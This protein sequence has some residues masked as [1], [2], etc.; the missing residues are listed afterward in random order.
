MKVRVP[1][2]P[3]ALMLAVY[4]EIM[5]RVNAELDKWKAAASAIENDELREQALSSIEKKAFHC[6]GGS[7]YALLAGEAM[8]EAVEF[9]VA[10]QTISDYL[11]NLCDRSNSQDPEDFEMLHNSMK[12]ALLPDTPL[13]DWYSLR[14]DREYHYLAALVA[15]CRRVIAK[16]GFNSSSST[17]KEMLKLN[18]MY[19]ALQVHKHVLVSERL[20]RLMDWEKSESADDT[21]PWQEFAAASGST[22]GIFCLIS[23]AL[24]WKG[25]TPFSSRVVRAYFPTIQCLHIMLDYFIDEQED[26]EDGELNFCTFYESRRALKSRVDEMIRT[27]REKTALLPDGDFHTMIIK[28]LVGLYLSDPKT[29]QLDLTMKEQW[30]GTAGLGAVFFCWNSKIYCDFIQKVR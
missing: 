29:R 21:L 5:P 1:R 12:E 28:G 9:I 2:N 8:D 7:V 17:I 26:E 22:L 23:Y 16:I 4:K 13:S 20:P 15:T 18:E 19:C 25:D 14:D 10:Y 24:L 30:L 27:G 3:A 6:Y 11:D